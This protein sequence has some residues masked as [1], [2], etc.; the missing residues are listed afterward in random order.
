MGKTAVAEAPETT[1]EP[2][3]T[4]PEPT[5]PEPADPEPVEPEEHA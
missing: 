3:P 4:E 2:E 5:E 1:T